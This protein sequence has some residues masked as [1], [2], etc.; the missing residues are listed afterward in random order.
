MNGKLI[1]KTAMIFM[2]SVVKVTVVNQTIDI[3]TQSKH[4]PMMK[5]MK[6]FLLWQPV[7]FPPVTVPNYNS[8]NRKL[9]KCLSDPEG[10]SLLLLLLLSR[11]PLP[12]PLH[13]PC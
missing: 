4:A 5:S 10:K 1:T 7:H 9:L 8:V 3:H 12:H 6:H 11:F 13:C 2:I